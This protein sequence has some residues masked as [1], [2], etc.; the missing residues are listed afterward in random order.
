[1]V[2]SVGGTSLAHKAREAILHSILERRFEDDRLPPENELATQLGVSRTTV[3]SAL[4]SL[5][6]HGVLTRSPRR[7][8]QV[9][10]KLSPSMVAL[11][12]LIGFKRLLEESGYTVETIT[13]NRKMAVAPP[14]VAETLALASGAAVYEISRLFV[15]SGKPAIWAINYLP[16]GLFA[17]TPSDGQLAQSPFDMG[18]L[19]MGGPVDHS[20]VELVPAR[21]TELVERKLGLKAED[22][23][24]LLKETHYSES[25]VA[26]GFSLIH[27]NDR[28]VRF[29]LYR[30]GDGR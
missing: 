28:F 10:N 29:K 26:L 23:Y 17:E 9:A 25:G 24:L 18:E 12:R 3:R 15:A 30:G 20:M 11:Q 5:E 21:P 14:E 13:T 16:A 2:D 27:V 1:M 8:T 19:L 7:G 4:Q 22:A 6:Q